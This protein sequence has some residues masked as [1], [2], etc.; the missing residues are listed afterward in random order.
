MS[1]L[2]LVLTGRAR[3]IDQRVALLA[4]RWTTWA[5]QTIHQRGS[6]R[7]AAIIEAMPWNRSEVTM[8]TWYGCTRTGW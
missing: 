1:S 8:Q 4:P 7:T 3:A 5:L 2:Q 6:M